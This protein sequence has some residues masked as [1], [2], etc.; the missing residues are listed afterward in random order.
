MLT[1]LTQLISDSV[2]TLEDKTTSGLA[3]VA[4]NRTDTKIPK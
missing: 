2:I 4:Q 3:R 1:A